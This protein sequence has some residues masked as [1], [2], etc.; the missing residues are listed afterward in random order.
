[1]GTEDTGSEKAKITEKHRKDYLLGGVDSGAGVDMG[2][3]ETK[4]A[5]T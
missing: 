3:N 2:R 5:S 1:L 4:K